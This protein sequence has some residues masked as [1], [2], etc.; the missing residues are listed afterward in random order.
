MRTLAAVAAL[1]CSGAVFA[2]NHGSVQPYVTGGFGSVVFRA[3]TP[4]PNPGLT[5]IT[6]N[7]V[8]P[9]GGGPH[10]VVPNATPGAK[11]SFRGNGASR[12]GYLYAYPVYV[13]SYGS[14][15]DAS[16]IPQQ[17]QQQPSPNI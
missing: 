6:P 12:G 8:D 11:S 16:A 10:L 3:G 15:Y 4:A 9:G 17:G 7:V 5:R 2:Q 1:F 13:G 14:V